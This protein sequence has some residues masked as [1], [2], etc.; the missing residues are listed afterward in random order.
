MTKSDVNAKAFSQYKQET[1][2]LN[3][4]QYYETDHSEFKFR[5][6]EPHC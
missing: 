2:F 4:R 6:D 1:V 3:K 5:S